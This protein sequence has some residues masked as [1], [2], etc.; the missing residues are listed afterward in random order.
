V[1]AAAG[2]IAVFLKIVGVELGKRVEGSDGF[3]IHGDSLV[4]V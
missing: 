1:Q 4:M 3:S 2:V